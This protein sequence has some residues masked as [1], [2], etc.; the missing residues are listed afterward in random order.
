MSRGAVTRERSS[1]AS[2]TSGLTFQYKGLARGTRNVLRRS[3][4]YAAGTGHWMNRCVRTG[5]DVVRYASFIVASFLFNS[6]FSWWPPGIFYLCTSAAIRGKKKEKKEKCGSRSEW[7]SFTPH[8]LFFFIFSL[9]P[10][11]KECML[12]V[13]EKRKRKDRWPVNAPRLCAC[14]HSDRPTGSRVAY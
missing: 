7:T 11:A 1:L 5:H 14:A 8:F 10:T 9:G 3:R 4:S 12:L 13:Q 6:F 2:P